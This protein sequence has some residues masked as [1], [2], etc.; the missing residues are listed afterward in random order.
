M[1]KLIFA[2]LSFI[3]VACSNQ[4]IEE[5]L[6]DLNA[7]L[8]ELEQQLAAVDANALITDINDIIAQVETIEQI[9]EE[10]KQAIAEAMATLTDLH[11]QLAAILVQI[12]E[13][14]T[15]E[16]LQAINEKVQSI[17]EGISMLVFVADYDYDGVMNGLDQC[18]DTPIT[19]ISQVN[20]VGCSPS[21][22]GG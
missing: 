6:D 3:L 5:G 22:L 4:S 17:S 11:D 7:R 20:G 18:P 21:Q 15:V 9:N 1:K 12:Q 2:V 13:A 10:N 8:V 16:Q 19:E 14:A